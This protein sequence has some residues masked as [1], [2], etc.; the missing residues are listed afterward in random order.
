MST[1]PT[2]CQRG[3]DI[4]RNA[5]FRELYQRWMEAKPGRNGTA[6]CEL[7]DTRK[8]LVSGYRTGY[9]NRI[10]PWWVL[11]RMAHDLGQEIRI[12]SA[13][14]VLT[15]RRG[16]GPGGPATRR[17]DYVASFVVRQ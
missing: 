17:G 5:L 3:A 14:A 15:T 4:D 13:G 2:S 12:T 8:Q 11:M 6:L 7:L 1:M 9:G 16:K 10:P